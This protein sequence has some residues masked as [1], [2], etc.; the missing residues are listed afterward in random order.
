MSGV[1]TIRVSNDIETY[2]LKVFWRKWYDED[3]TIEGMPE[4]YLQKWNTI[5]QKIETGQ[6]FDI[7]PFFVIPAS[8]PNTM[9]Q[10]TLTGIFYALGFI[11]PRVEW[12]G[13]TPYPDPEPLE[14]SGRLIVE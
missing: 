13:D 12:V 11:W 14:A 8:V 3:A 6:K 4:D 5:V 2:D 10:K 7:Q 1:A 9:V